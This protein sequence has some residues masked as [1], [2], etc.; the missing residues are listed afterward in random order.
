MHLLVYE[1]YRY[2][3]ARYKDKKTI[4]FFMRIPYELPH[5]C[6]LDSVSTSLYITVQIHG[7]C[8]KRS[9]ALNP[10]PRRVKL[11]TYMYLCRI[12]WFLD[13]SKMHEREWVERNVSRRKRKGGYLATP[14]YDELP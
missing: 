13:F 14:M 10:F 1:H 3:N 9:I 6:R 12:A 2:Q 7:K 5:E 8:L 4:N 11:E